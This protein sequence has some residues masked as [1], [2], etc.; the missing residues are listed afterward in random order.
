MA[1]NYKMTPF[2]KFFIF[3]IIAVPLSFIGAS[4]YNGQ[5]PFKAIKEMEI[6]KQT[7]IRVQEKSD[8]NN[9]SSNS[10][11]KELELKNMEIKQLTDKIL[12]LEDLI[13]VQKK[14]IENLKSREKK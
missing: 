9:V 12:M 4:Y 13:E 10:I 11:D 2:A 7:E 8:I 14:E 5:D 6:F 1:K 3:L